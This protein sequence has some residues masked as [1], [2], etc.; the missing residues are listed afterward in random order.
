[1]KIIPTNPATAR[2]AAVLCAGASALWG[3]LYAMLGVGLIIPALEERALQFGWNVM[4][5]EGFYSTPVMYRPKPSFCFLWA[6][7]YITLGYAIFISNSRAAA[8]LFVAVQLWFTYYGLVQTNTPNMIP[9]I[10]L[11]AA[12]VGVSGTVGYKRSAQTV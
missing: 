12:L 2:R 4:A 10:L 11:V 3:M 1:M 9:A 8:I 6:Y 7:L 5:N